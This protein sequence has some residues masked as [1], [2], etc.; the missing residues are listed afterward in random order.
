MKA[1]RLA[2]A[3][4]QAA[5]RPALNIAMARAY[6]TDRS[7]LMAKRTWETVMTAVA[8]CGGAATQQRCLRAMQSEPFK[9]LR[10]IRLVETDSQM[11]FE[12]LHHKKA[13][14]STNNW[15]RRLHNHALDLGWLLTPI[16]ARK[17]WPVM[18]HKISYAIT[19]EEHQRI[20]E[21]ES[22][23]ERRL[24]YEMLWHTGG[25]QSDVV[26]LTWDAIDPEEGI[27]TYWRS[28]RRPE[29]EPAHIKIGQY[30]QA[31]LDQLPQ[32][33][34]FFPTLRRIESKHRSTEFRR[35]CRILGIK[36]KTLKSYRNAWTERARAAGM[37]LRE[38]MEWVGHTSQAVHRAYAKDA[39][40]VCLPLEYYEAERNRQ[41]MEFQ[42][43]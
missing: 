4:N 6:L 41:M 39:R 9:P 20:I 14:T 11:F 29:S 31:V 22:N 24:Y 30:L 33:G 13:G 18:Q 17:A 19:A 12:V 3:R 28:K 2:V 25:S 15:L 36:N 26:N 42:M 35:R 37:P 43:Q 21:T 27:L 40:F 8:K 5:D 1:R 7:P 38:A 23:S 32:P 16:M 34:A 10:K